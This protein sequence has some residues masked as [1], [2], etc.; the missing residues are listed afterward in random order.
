MEAVFLADASEGIPWTVEGATVRSATHEPYVA[1]VDIKTRIPGV[2]PL[3][4]LGSP[5]SLILR[6]D[7]TENV[8]AGIVSS[9]RVRHDHD[10]DAGARVVIEPALAVLRHGRDSR[11]FQEKSVP[12]I[13][14]E[15]LT[16]ALA[17]YGREVQVEVQRTYP[18]REYTVQYQESHFDFVHRLMEEEGILYRF[19]ATGDAERMVLFDDPSQHPAMDE[20]LLEYSDT[21][22]GGGLIEQEYVRSFEPVTEL[23]R[24]E[25]KTRHFDWTHPS[26]LIEGEAAGERPG[27]GP[28]GGSFGPT[29]ESYEH[30]EAFTL[31]EYQLAYR[32]H[33]VTDQQRL[34]REA[35][36]RDAR[37]FTGKST[38][39]GVRCG[40]KFALN[41]HP[42]LPLNAEYTIVRAT[43]RL[44]THAR[45][46]L[47]LHY[48]NEMTVVL[49]DVPYRPKRTRQ[50]PRVHGLQ[51]AIVTG[52]AGEEIHTDERGRVKVQ[53]HW[54]RLGEMDE[55]TTCWIRC[56]QTWSGNAWGAFVLPR[57]GMEVVVSF[58]DGD[59]DRPLVTGC[60]YNGDNDVPYPLPDKK[61]VSTFKTNS[62]PG[63]DG[64][65]EL[66]FDDTKGEE[67]IWVHGEKDWNTVIENDLY[68]DVRHDETQN[69][70]RNRTRTVGNDER[71]TVDKNRVKTVHVNETLN[72]GA[73]RTR[74]VGANE[75]VM[76]GA[77]RTAGVVENENTQ[78][79]GHRTMRVGATHLL[80]AGDSLEL[81][82]G[83]SRI[84]M[85]K[86]GT[87]TIEGTEFRFS[88][89]GDVF[90]VGSLIHLN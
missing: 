90:V 20:A 58:L 31:N 68:R 7:L 17:P 1:V 89:S 76:V 79:G 67:E 69:V 52:P 32:A 65:N 37:R 47:G 61:M 13:L 29:R 12:T 9:V 60:V 28:D 34:R 64:Y 77:N 10:R 36:W 56:M 46:D 11:I 78:V 57:V 27:E 8:Y 87:I 33:D 72:V 39:L 16:E 81:R 80:T 25:V 41:G 62:Y 66:R 19:E 2:D 45:G 73:N 85:E 5:A 6:R 40:L 3:E 35:Q 88:A 24:T 86:D 82:C 42:S 63:G 59:L 51:T 55:K 54:D 48:D 43:H 21:V 84:F 26:V 30:D 83:Q 4:L 53:F 18:L 15:V 44:G 75:T 23:G 50:R 14:A 74:N 71:V 22:G 49:G 70:V 38:V